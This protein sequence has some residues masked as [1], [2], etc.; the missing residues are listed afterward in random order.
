MALMAVSFYRSELMEQAGFPHHGFTGVDGG[1]SRG[2]YASLNLAYGLEDDDRCVSENLQILREAVG[3]ALPLARVSQ[4]HK[5]GVVLSEEVA[6]DDWSAPP[7]TQ[8]DAIVSDG[9]A[10]VAVQTADCAAVLLA[11]PETRVVAAVHAGWRGTAAGVLRTAIRRMGDLGAESNRLLA[12]IG[13]HICLNCYEVGE[14]VAGRLPESAD[15]IRRRP[16]KYQL[17]LA[18]AI[19]VSLLV[20]GVATDRVE[21]IPVCTSCSPDGL[22]SYRRS[23]GTCGRMLGFIASC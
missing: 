11:D 21:R 9:G 17:D 15:P 14:D 12:V 16:G 5:T 7:V 2:A 8:A 10:V 18:N 6:S 1:V 22:F 23:G 3:T 19:E 20:S 13:P 4:V